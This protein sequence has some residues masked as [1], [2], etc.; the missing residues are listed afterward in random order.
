VCTR[1]A[2]STV[3]LFGG[4]STVVILASCSGDVPTGAHDD[5]VSMGRVSEAGVSVCDRSRSAGVIVDVARSDLAAHQ[6]HGDYVTSLVVAQ[7]ADQPDDGVHFRR[8]GDALAVA[9][10]GRLARGELQS[11]ACRITITIGPG[12]IPGTT[13]DR[14]DRGLEHFPIVV[15]VPDITL[16][17][18]LV[19]QLD[20]GGRATGAR[21]GPFA[22]TLSPVEPLPIVDGSSTPLIIANG[23][24]G[25]SA[26][27]GLDVEGFVLQSGQRLGTG[28]GGQGVF[29]MRVA[30]L[31][32]RGN[33]FEAGFTEVLDLR[34]TSA[35]VEQNHLGGSA[36]TCDI[37][38]AGP[39]V[40]HVTGN[41]LLAGGIPGILTVPVVGLPVPSAVE[42]FDLPAA[43]EVSAEVR[44]NEVRD[45][46]RV[47]VGV[48]V[49]VGAIGLG[50]P[51]V[52]GSAHVTIRDNLL[53]NNNFALIIEAAFP[54]LGTDRKGDIDVT[55]GG[56]VMQQSCQTNLLVS[57]SRHTTGLGLTDF[58]YLLNSTYTVALGGNIRWEDVWF[59][60]PGGFGNTLVVDGQPIAN[61]TRVFYD[62]N[63]CPGA[64][65]S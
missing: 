32:I 40:Y 31:N 57:L 64:T 61:G 1:Q 8:I 28:V 15:D 53:V 2:R 19:M 58:P 48:G 62:P 11:A 38:L 41:R 56:N 47:P 63:T 16:R 36:G 60:H 26:G 20:A 17:G 35:V 18:A 54:V 30:G 34:A 10:A 4:L 44:N 23:H 27:N 65:A 25:G 46:L 12:V 42:P 37:C 59:S 51:N 3:I 50:A 7:N 49:R 9:R 33:K 24:P 14:T 52:H 21:V 45:H 5:L 22:T 6:S 55:L 39:G 13:T 29:G 43:S